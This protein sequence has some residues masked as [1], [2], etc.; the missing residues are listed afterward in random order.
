[1]LFLLSHRNEGKGRN[2]FLCFFA[3]CGTDKLFRLFISVDLL[4]VVGVHAGDG[5]GTDAVEGDDDTAVL[6][7]AVDGALDT[8]EETGDDAH[9]TTNLTCEVLVAKEHDAVVVDGGDAHEV[10]HVTR[11]D[12]D[13]VRSLEGIVGMPHEEPQGQQG[14]TGA[15]GFLEPR[16]W[17]MDEEEVVDGGDELDAT[18]SVNEHA[19]M[20]HGQEGLYL[21][22]VEELLDGEGA[23]STSIG[24]A[25]GE[26]G[27]GSMTGGRC[28]KC[29]FHSGHRPFFG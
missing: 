24:D 12:G 17:G 16:L 14:L 29:I 18:A 8:L 25:Q 4:E 5:D 23:L 22:V 26:P 15:L 9:T 7:D 3:F 13:D 21:T 6:L 1:M 11:G 2:D 28:E 27:V 10:G 19:L 20:C